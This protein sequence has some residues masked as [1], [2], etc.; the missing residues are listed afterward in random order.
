MDDAVGLRIQ[1]YP[2]WEGRVKMSIVEIKIIRNK[3]W[4]DMIIDYSDKS[5]FGCTRP[6]LSEIIKELNYRIKDSWRRKSE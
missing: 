4:W 5:Q 2:S 1:V 3:T 6:M